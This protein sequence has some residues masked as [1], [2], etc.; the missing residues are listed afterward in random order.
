MT[1]SFAVDKGW[2]YSTYEIYLLICGSQGISGSSGGS[3][4]IGGQGGYNGTSFVQN[5]ETGQPFQI[6]TVKQG[7]S[8]GSNGENG[9]IGKSGRHG[10]DG[11]D[12]ALIDRSASEASKHFEGS[13]NRKL[14]WNYVYKE[15]YKSHQNRYRRCVEKESACFIKFGASETIDTSEWRVNKAQERTTRTSASEAVA[16]Q[17]IF[18]SQVLTETGALFWKQ[19][20]LLT[21]VCKAIADVTIN[22]EEEEVENVTEEV[23][24]LRQREEVN[25][26]VK[27]TPESEKKVRIENLQFKQQ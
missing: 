21:D 15:E 12:M 1:Y 14:S 8:S 26:L 10:I 27:Y 18:I 2:T 4:G 23:V 20:A 19:N 3:N 11:N 9:I 5:P 7:K 24:V 13:S 6:N 22:T 17:S 25:Q 16:K